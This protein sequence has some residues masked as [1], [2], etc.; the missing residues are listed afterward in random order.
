MADYV[1]W[2]GAIASTAIAVI[3]FVVLFS[4]LRQN[5]KILEKKTYPAR[6]SVKYNSA[7]V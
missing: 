4:S 2:W 7:K 6:S 3:S 5:K 1:A